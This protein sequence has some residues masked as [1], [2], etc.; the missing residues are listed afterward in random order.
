MNDLQLTNDH[1]IS[2]TAQIIHQ[3]RSQVLQ[4]VSSV[5]AQSC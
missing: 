4:T 1:L 3:A 2:N 5:M